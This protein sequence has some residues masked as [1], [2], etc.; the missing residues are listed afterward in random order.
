[1]CLCVFVNVCMCVCEYECV[2]EYV[3][4]CECEYVCMCVSV[5]KCVCG[6]C[7]YVYDTLCGPVSLVVTRGQSYFPRNTGPV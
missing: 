5:C 3:Y 2:C 1:M 6:V 4:L 7:V